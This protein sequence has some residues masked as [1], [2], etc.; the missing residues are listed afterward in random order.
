MH[1]S[2]RGRH[3]GLNTAAAAVLV[4]VTSLAA[5][6]AGAVPATAHP[7]PHSVVLLDV[8]PD[9]VDAQLQLPVQDLQLASGLAT[10]ERP[11]QVVGQDAG[12][13][14]SYLVDHLRADSGG[15]P[16]SVTVTTLRVTASEQTATGPYREI[17]ADAVLTPPAGA[18]TRRFTLDDEVI[19]HQVATHTILL[20]LRQDWATGR[21]ATD[22]ARQLGVIRTDSRTMTVPRLP[23]DLDDGTTWQG[24]LAMLRLGGRHIAEGTDHLLFLLT[25]LLPA[26]LLASGRRWV[27]PAGL[28]RTG[29]AIARITTAFTVGHSVALAVSALTGVQAPARPV[30]ALIAVSIMISAA[31][32]VRPLF[33]GREALIAAAFGLV[34]GMAF[35][36]A[37]RDLHLST[38]QLVVSLVGFNLGIELVQLLVV[39]LVLPALVLLG[40]TSRYRWVTTV[41]GALAGTAALGW[42]LDRLGR[43]NPVATLADLLGGYGWYIVAA[44]WL[45]ALATRVGAM[46]T[47][48]RDR[49]VA[50]G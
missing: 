42:L 19:V 21:L 29:V 14:R 30:E 50:P 7:M 17:V 36:F 3:A 1:P 47:P 40:R 26:A 24:F 20:A 48:R 49:A 5:S 2:P 46:P 27:G 22:G 4:I 33:P 16:W 6:L 35:S 25:L 28:R 11:E 43:P 9:R 10:A 18:G 32:A 8:H 31:H 15:R 12:L 45:L 38:G 23:V 34:H 13:L 41:G 44:L 39:A 37:L